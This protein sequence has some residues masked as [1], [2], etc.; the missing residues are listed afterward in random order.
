MALSDTATRS[1]AKSRLSCSTNAAYTCSCNRP[2]AN[3]FSSIVNEYLDKTERESR[4]PITLEKNR[5]LFS[6]MNADLGKRP[7]T[8]ITPADFLATLQKVEKRGHLETARRMR[9]LSGRI[10]RYAVAT[11][12]AAY[13][14]GAHWQERVE[15][16]GWWSDYLD[17]LRDGGEAVPFGKRA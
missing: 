14:R 5:W 7:I 1:M 3:S 16:A 11:S 2:A 6:L 9:S 4:A 13:H 15:M 17:R 12:R 8:A 10:F